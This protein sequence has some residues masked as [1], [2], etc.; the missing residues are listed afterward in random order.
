[1]T[2]LEIYNPDKTYM[3]PDMKVATPD[4]IKANYSAVNNFKCVI[5]T[6]ESGEM[7]FGIEPFNAMKQRLGVASG[8]SDEETLKAMEDILNKPVPVNTEPSA[9]ERIASALEYQ[10][11][12]AE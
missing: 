4:Q 9:Q 10:N 6:D 8:L 5:Y 7:L 3:T 1:M 11:L 2:N 12:L